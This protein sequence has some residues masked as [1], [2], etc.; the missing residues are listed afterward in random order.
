MQINRGDMLAYAESYVAE[1]FYMQ[2]AR[3]NGAEVGAIDPT[4]AVG[5]LIKYLIKS[6]KSRSVVEIGTG[7]GVGG[8]WIF[9]GLN[10]DGVLTTIDT[11]REFSKIA[12]QIFQDAEIAPTLYRIITGNLIE[13]VDKLADNNYDFVVA[14]C[15]NELP[16]MVHAAA[17]LLKVGGIFLIDAVMAGG[18]VADATQRDS[19]SIARRDAIKLIQE[20]KRWNSTLLPIGAGVL[21]AHKLM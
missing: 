14:R 16:D 18:K 17:R 6:A 20:D 4:A 11:E 8:L 15:S 3:K 13:V 5:N 9:A 1:D 21:V 7:S 10:N 12:K 2:Q 19:E